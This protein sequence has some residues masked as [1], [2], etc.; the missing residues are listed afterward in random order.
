MSRF[1]GRSARVIFFMLLTLYAAYLVRSVAENPTDLQWDFTLYYYAAETCSHDLNPYVTA[2]IVQVSGRKDIWLPYIYPPLTLW[3]FRPF[4]CMSYNTAF[5][6]WLALKA[7]L[8][9]ILVLVWK[10]YFLADSW[11][12]F[13]CLFFLFAFDSALYWDLK[14]GNLSLL[15][16]GVLWAAFL[17]L[18]KEKPALF[19]LL[20]VGISFFKITTLSFLVLLPVSR[21]DRKWWYFGG[22]LAAFGIV[23]GLDYLARPDLFQVF[24]SRAQGLAERA[25]NHN[26][27]LLAFFQD[28]FELG[29][30]GRWASV[31]S[32]LPV[33]AYGLTTGAVLFFTGRAVHRWNPSGHGRDYKLIIFLFCLA[34]ALTFPRLKCYSLVLLIVPS[35]YLIQAHPARWMS[36]ALFLLLLI[37]ANTPLPDAQWIRTLFAYYPLM[38]AFI[39]WGFYITYFNEQAGQHTA[40]VIPTP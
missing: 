36:P 17:A 1:I 3:F 6:L 38:L 13:F 27:G 23:L 39:F 35:Y 25:F 14:S 8:M 31:A 12:P 40:D 20:I 7:C 24:L 37:P 26:Y 4:T 29:L 18:I 11:S 28:A 5:Y 33:L 34:Y 2:D 21:F 16:Q 22:A 15:E 10:R 19:A 30:R 32:L 9:V